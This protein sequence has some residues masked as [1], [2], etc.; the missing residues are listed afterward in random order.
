MVSGTFRCFDDRCETAGQNEPTL[1][2]E[3]EMVLVEEPAEIKRI[4]E[5]R[6]EKKNR[7]EGKRTNGG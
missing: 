2:A 4:R 6:K 7:N 5:K 1:L 3:R